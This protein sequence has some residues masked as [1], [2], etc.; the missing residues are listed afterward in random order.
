MRATAKGGAGSDCGWRSG[1][2]LDALHG[3][4]DAEPYADADDRAGEPGVSGRAS[5]E[6]SC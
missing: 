6:W 2:L 1:N 5:R 4:A 3:Q